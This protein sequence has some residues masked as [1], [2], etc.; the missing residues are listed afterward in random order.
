M[1]DI[2]RLGFVLPAG[3]TTVE[4]EFP[5]RLQGT[6][7]AHFQRFTRLVR[8]ASD[9]S[10]PERAMVDA[11]GALR[12]AGVSAVAL[13]YTAG[14]YYGGRELDQRLIA[15]MSE[16]SGAPATTA[17]DGITS[18]LHAL[19]VT[20]LGVVSPYKKEINDHCEQYLAKSG[21]RVMSMVGSPPPGPAGAVPIEDIARMAASAAG[22]DV[23]AVLISCTAL[24]TMTVLEELEASLGV[25]VVSSNSATLWSILQLARSSARIAGLGKLLR[26]PGAA[27]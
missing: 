27:A 17:A 11:A 21:F 18:G 8:A 10:E 15:R 7:T 1:M 22:G 20:R 25:P 19:G 5:P 2:I 13:A 14:S 23:E 16:V 12:A 4:T 26:R 6:A 9:I 3:N 24:R